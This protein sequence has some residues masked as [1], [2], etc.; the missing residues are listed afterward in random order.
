MSE[1]DFNKA[2]IADLERIVASQAAAYHTLVER[3]HH[4][5]EMFETQTFTYNTPQ[6][7][8]VLNAASKV[9]VVWDNALGYVLRD[10]EEI[11]QAI[12]DLQES[13]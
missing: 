13:L 3:L 8:A 11:I 4:Y 5:E 2:R 10:D 12:R 9:Q 7:Q 1:V 6:Q